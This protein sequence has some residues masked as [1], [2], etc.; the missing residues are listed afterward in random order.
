MW[1]WWLLRKLRGV[2]RTDAVSRKTPTSS[3]KY[4]RKRPPVRSGR[5]GRN[6]RPALERTFLSCFSGLVPIGERI[7]RRH[8]S[9][10]L[11]ALAAHRVGDPAFEPF[12]SQVS[13]HGGKMSIEDA[14]DTAGPERKLGQEQSLADLEQALGNRE[15][16]LGD[17]AQVEVDRAQAQLDRDRETEGAGDSSAA[18]VLDDRQARVNRTQATQD[19]QQQA[20]DSSQAGRDVQQGA[21]DE[22]REVH[23]RPLSEQ[24]QPRTASKL[25][26]D[27]H[28]RATAARERAEA[29]LMR[30]QADLARA[31]AVEKRT[32]HDIDPK[33]VEFFGVLPRL[34][35]GVKPVPAYAEKSQAGGYYEPGSIKAGRPGYF[36]AN[37]YDLPGRPKWG[38]E[39]SRSTRLCRGITSRLRSRKRPKTC[40]SF[41]RMDGYNAFGEGWALYAESLGYEMGFFK[42]P[43]QHFGHLADEMLRAVRLVV[44]TGLHSMGWTR[45]QAIKFFE[46]NTGNPPHDIEVEIDRYIVWP[47]RRWATRSGN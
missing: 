7:A 43:Y 33:L 4:A 28:Q 16:L 13:N 10:R 39:R 45:E 34:P 46:E 5:R 40:P 24:P 31:D 2:H 8:A 27:A 14:Y 41:G 6:V 22:L 3:A 42:D 20:L 47:R 37:T 9:L 19:T 11:A 17:R 29:A 18:R 32:R 44:D 26:R 25:Q 23:G 30:A 1:S 15:Q 35:Y 12:D 21:M 38:M 36:F